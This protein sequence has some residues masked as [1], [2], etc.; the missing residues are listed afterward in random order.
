MKINR[1]LEITILLLNRGT[2][3]AKELAAKF[4]V[5]TRTIYRDI[6]ILSTAGV[7]VYMN[8]GNGG[9]I[10]LLED[11]SFNKAL[12]SEHE[13]E[14]IILALKAMQVT[15]YP[16]IEAVLN[17]LGSVF[18][19]IEPDNWIEIN[20]SPWG[21]SP[22]EH[23]KFVDIK[24][25][26]TDKKIITFNYVNSSGEKS[27]RSMEPMKLIFKGQAWY[28]WGYCATRKDFRIFRISRIKDLTVTNNTFVRRK[29]D[30]TVKYTDE[31]YQIK[32]VELKLKFLPQVIHRAYDDFDERFI[33]KN[34][35]GTCDVTITFPEDE[36]VY[37][38]ILSFGCYVKVLEPEHIKKIIS[39][40]MKKA[41]DFYKNDF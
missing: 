23:N 32:P 30:E 9:G 20:F 17:K 15:K 19:N 39:D 16:E 27:F 22:N 5:S 29:L 33:S 25:A 11:Y 14:S 13:S 37:G 21:S 26:V 2:I 12:I 31:T 1:L 41:L 38:Y 34:S 35:D 7:P 18:K 4:D 10:S 24:K 36:W 40:R 28:L 3:T 6:D 8:K